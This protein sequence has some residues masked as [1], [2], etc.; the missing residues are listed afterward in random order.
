MPTDRLTI[1]DLPSAP[2]LQPAARPIDTYQMPTRENVA[3]PPQTNAL[4]QVAVALS[5]LSKPLMQYAKEAKQIEDEKQLARG[6]VAWVVNDSDIKTAVE[7]N[8]FRA[9]IH[10]ALIRGAQRAAL[11]DRAAKY[12]AHLHE[13]WMKNGE[14]Q[15]SFDPATFDTFI[16]NT[17]T[18][19]INDMLFTANGD[20]R[21]NR[22]DFT[23]VFS[24]LMQRAEHTL[25]SVHM[26]R[27]TAEWEQA[28]EEQGVNAVI[29]LLNGSLYRK[30]TRPMPFPD[31][32]PAGLPP[33][34][35]ITI[36]PPPGNRKRP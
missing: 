28:L 8:N 12:A 9:D 10:P 2:G 32:L 27:R 17:R 4:A 3:H 15:N 1:P 24:P 22:L 21:F 18:P 29:A 20:T 30:G 11:R 26:E 7:N 36:P 31:P 13:Q 14:V 16:Q 5:S 19:F 33:L 25:Q 34:P 35:P 23:E 6:E